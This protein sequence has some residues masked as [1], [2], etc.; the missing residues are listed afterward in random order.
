MFEHVKRTEAKV[1]LAKNND[2]SATPNKIRAQTTIKSHRKQNKNNN[3]A[4]AKIYMLHLH[5][6]VIYFIM[7]LFFIFHYIKLINCLEWSEIE[8]GE[9]AISFSCL[10]FER[11]YLLS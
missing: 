1:S 3:N 10:V 8:R 6:V 9:K 4:S 7:L 5:H 11:V 2:V